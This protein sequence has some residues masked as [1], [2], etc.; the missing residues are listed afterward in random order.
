MFVDMTPTLELA[1][2]LIARLEQGESIANP[3]LSQLLSLLVA[4][5]AYKSP[6]SDGVRYDTGDA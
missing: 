2:L 1:E 5:P 4:N 3:Q 6:A